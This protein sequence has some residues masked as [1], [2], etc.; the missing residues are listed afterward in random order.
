VTIDQGE[1]VTAVPDVAEFERAG[2][3]DRDAPGA[4]ERLNL[5]RVVAARGGSLAEMEAAPGDDE[6]ERLAAE[7]FFL[8]SSGRQT[9]AELAAAVGI[10]V[11]DVEWMLRVCGLPVPA[12]AERSFSTADAEVVRAFREAVDLF[13]QE[14]AVEL[15]R[16]AGS[17]MEHVADAAI[18][19]FVTTAG[20]ASL[21]DDGVLLETT[22]RVA[23]LQSRFPT[24]LASLLRH[25]LVRLARPNRTGTPTD[26]EVAG[27]AVGFVDLVGF[28]S[29]AQRVDLDE[30]GHLL[31]RFEALAKECLMACGGRVVKFVGDAVMF[32]AATLADACTSALDLVGYVADR[33][34][35]DARGGVAAGDV[36]VRAGDCFGPVVNLAARAACVAEAS[37]VLASVAD[38]DGLPDG[39]L[40]TPRPPMQLAGIDIPVVLH[41]V[42][43]RR[44]PTNG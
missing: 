40:A 42:Q 25:Q 6:L 21:A 16:V 9:L 34:G 36:L 8:P 43:R 4:V 2:L 39:I 13:G 20:A 23:T 35:L 5:L 15:L 3:Y 29:L 17:A 28:T 10:G 32:R 22:A 41:Q 19:T 38:R 12:V 31:S 44:T 27:A 26:F 18:S 11:E 1:R 37:M 24:V 7:L 14:P 33:L 30:V